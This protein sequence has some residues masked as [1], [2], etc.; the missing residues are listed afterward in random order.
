M[1]SAGE[2]PRRITPS[3]NPAMNQSQRNE[4]MSENASLSEAKRR[5]TALTLSDKLTVLAGGICFIASFLP[6]FTVSFHVKNLPNAGG[7]STSAW[8]VGFGGWFPVV[9]LTALAVA[10]VV[11]G[12]GAL[13]IQS[14]NA[15]R[16]AQL[17]APPAAAV[18][19][20]IRWVSFPGGSSVYGSSGAGFGLFVG[21]AAALLGCIG[22][23]GV[24]KHRAN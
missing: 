24:L 16:I 6:W 14:A 1:F 3:I 15:L 18:I 21:L 22:S 9:L 13:P 5:W 7:A 4:P 8:N 20:L 2:R 19:I 11:R 12:V 17:I 23:Y 10:V